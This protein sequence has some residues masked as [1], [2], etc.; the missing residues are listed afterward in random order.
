MKRQLMSKFTANKV[1][2][3]SKISLEIVKLVA[4]ALMF[5]FVLN[6]ELVVF[7]K[8]FIS[9]LPAGSTLVETIATRGYIYFCLLS[10]SPSLFALTLVLIQV[11]LFVQVVTIIVYVFCKQLY[12]TKENAAIEYQKKENKFYRNNRTVYLENSSLLL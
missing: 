1:N 4:M 3:I 2:R 9:T 5:L 11:F 8:E 10:N 7:V 6:K 12:Y